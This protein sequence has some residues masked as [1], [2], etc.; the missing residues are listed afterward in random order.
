MLLL[1]LAKSLLDIH[2]PSR[3]QISPQDG[4][5][6]HKATEIMTPNFE[7]HTAC[8]DASPATSSSMLLHTFLTHKAS[9]KLQVH[10]C[11]CH[12]ARKALLASA[13]VLNIAMQSTD[14]LGCARVLQDSSG[15]ISGKSFLQVAWRT[16]D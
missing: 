13:L 10:E 7:R 2:R 14:L 3:S 5:V 1:M 8:L 16:P 12:P 6:K 11:D 4:S 15:H 9:A